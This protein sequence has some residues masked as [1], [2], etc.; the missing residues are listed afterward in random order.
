VLLVVAFALVVEWRCLI[1]WISANEC[2]V[3][4]G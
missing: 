1:G 3:W 4:D 2:H